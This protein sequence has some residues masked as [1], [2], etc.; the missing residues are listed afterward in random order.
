MR[1]SDSLRLP[2]RV[3]PIRLPFSSLKLFTGEFF[4]TWSDSTSMSTLSATI[5][6]FTPRA[7]PCSAGRAAPRPNRLAPAA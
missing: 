4:G 7:I 1:T 3:M 6:I 5:V 2:N